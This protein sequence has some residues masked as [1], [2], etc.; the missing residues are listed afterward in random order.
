MAAALPGVI[1]DH[2]GPQFA[3]PNALVRT[4][5][6]T[7]SGPERPPNLCRGDFGPGNPPLFRVTV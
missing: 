1:A 5:P 2:K 3:V 6:D 7:S 4:R